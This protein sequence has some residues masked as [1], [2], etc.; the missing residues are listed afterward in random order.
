MLF[1]GFSPFV[2]VFLLCIF[3]LACALYLYLVYRKSV[4]S[5]QVK[6]L[7]S[8]LY[9]FLS[10]V[11]RAISTVLSHLVTMKLVLP[12]SRIK[13]WLNILGGERL[14]ILQ[15]GNQFP[16]TKPLTKCPRSDKQE[17]SSPSNNK[18]VEKKTLPPSRHAKTQLPLTLR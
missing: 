4:E 15:V 8:T 2:W 1:H 6:P 14:N 10:P 3:M 17:S 9:K 5:N 16:Y 18:K 11:L 7:F 12:S 13:A